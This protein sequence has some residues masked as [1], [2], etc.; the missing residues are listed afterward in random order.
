MTLI[1]ALEKQLD[2]SHTKLLRAALNLSSNDHISNKELY[3]DLPP[4]ST[5]L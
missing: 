1:T 5:N 2:G 3:G 4:I